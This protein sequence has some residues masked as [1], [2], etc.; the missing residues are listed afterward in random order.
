MR[1]RFY[2]SS[3]LRSCVPVSGALQEASP[4]PGRGSGRF[5]G[6][7]G[8]E[9]RRR[10][11]AAFVPLSRCRASRPAAKTRRSGVRTRLARGG[12][13]PIRKA[14]IWREQ[15]GRSQL[16]PSDPPRVAS[17]AT[18]L[19]ISILRR[20]RRDGAELPPAE[21]ARPTGKRRRVEDGAF[22]EELRSR[23]RQPVGARTPHSPGRHRLRTARQRR[24]R[25]RTA[26]TRLLLRAGA[27]HRRGLSPEEPVLSR[28]GS[29]DAAGKRLRYAIT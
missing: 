20:E 21:A 7:H 18:N 15:W 12:A 17:A 27:E 1:D 19:S 3:T 29:E 22:V 2:A 25:G 11:P 13:C 8:R 16:A 4:L 9:R 10:T 14:C 5:H 6:F 23:G 28:R 24:R 26:A